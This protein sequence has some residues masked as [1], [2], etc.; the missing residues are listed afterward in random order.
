[1]QIMFE[2]ER[3]RQVSAE[4]LTLSKT[5]RQA[6]AELTDIRQALRTETEFDACR[7]NLKHREEDAALLTARL[8]SLSTALNEISQLYTRAENGNAELLDGVSGRYLPPASATLYL[9]GADT[10]LRMER[11]LQQ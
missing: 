2:R 11:I 10:H 9:N 6:G 4:L 7:R 5:L 1:M 3:V 8:V